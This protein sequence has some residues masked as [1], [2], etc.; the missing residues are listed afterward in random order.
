MT[1]YSQPSLVPTNLKYIIS[2]TGFFNHRIN[3][4][5]SNLT[6]YFQLILK[7]SQVLSNLIN[8]A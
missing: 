5:H 3:L 4:N 1:L 7:P 6:K 8:T 2:Q